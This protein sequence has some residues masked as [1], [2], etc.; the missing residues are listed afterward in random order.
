M[1]ELRKA[2]NTD[3]H[4]IFLL[5]KTVL[6][7]YGLKT[8]PERTDKDISDLDLYYFKN[9]GWFA[10]IEDKGKIIGSYG[11]YHIDD[12]T[13]ELR[14]MYL[15]PGF[16]GQG[17]GKLMMQDAI[18]RAEKLGYNEMILETNKVLDKAIGL[19]KKYGFT[20]FVPEHLSSRCDLAMKKH[21]GNKKT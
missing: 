5:V 4:N 7:D 17:L 16:Q 15:L 10:V 11:I 19:Y 13:C 8:D 21:I 18:H 14:K 20:E 12:Y 1:P 3:Q 9:K 2:D 6:S